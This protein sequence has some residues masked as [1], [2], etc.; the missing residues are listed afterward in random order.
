[1]IMDS[2]SRKIIGYEVYD[3]ETGELASE[4]F[5]RTVL[6]EGCR[7]KGLVIHADNGATQR[8]STLRV[9]LDELGLRTSC[10]RPRVSS[11]NAH[12]ESL[13]RTAKYRHDILTRGIL[14]LAR[15][16]AI[17]SKIPPN[18]WTSKANCQKGGWQ[19]HWPISP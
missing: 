19:I 7:G 3:S 9:K 2:L 5:D 1:M 10:S 11:D 17:K 4:L 18:T 16:N 14:D 12:V 15:S 13:F 6:A 8:S